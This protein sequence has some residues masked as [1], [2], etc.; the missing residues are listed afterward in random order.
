[1]TE[2]ERA[3]EAWINAYMGHDRGLVEGSLKAAF[4]AGWK[5]ERARAV[6]DAEGEGRIVDYTGTIDALRAEIGGERAKGE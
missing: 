1:M 5:R 6:V 4:L 2:Q 3:F